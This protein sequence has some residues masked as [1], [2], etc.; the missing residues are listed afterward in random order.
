MLLKWKINNVMNS[1]WFQA[2]DEEKYLGV[3]IDNNDI[4]WKWLIDVWNPR[5][6]LKRCNI[7]E[8]YLKEQGGYK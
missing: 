2:V 3:I 1:Y 8:Y 5:I 6:E 4:I 7:T